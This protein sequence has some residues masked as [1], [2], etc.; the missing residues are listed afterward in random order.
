[1]FQLH[2]GFSARDAPA[3]AAEFHAACCEMQL[4]QRASG[5]IENRGIQTRLCFRHFI[6]QSYLLILF[7]K[8]GAHSEQNCTQIQRNTS[9][10]HVHACPPPHRGD[11]NMHFM[12][13]ILS[14][15]SDVTFTDL[16]FGYH[17][18][19]CLLPAVN[20]GNLQKKD[21]KVA[22]P[23]STCSLASSKMPQYEKPPLLAMPSYLACWAWLIG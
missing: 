16:Y 20:M 7:G 13:C 9:N 8:N 6:T 3:A 14:Y 19:P 21:N 18:K 1:M 15:L 10:T 5:S 11:N 23:V 22:E 12:H 17:K 2:S 4:Q